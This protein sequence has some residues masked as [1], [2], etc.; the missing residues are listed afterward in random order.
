MTV[1]TASASNNL[2]FPSSCASSIFMIEQSW[3]SSTLRILRSIGSLVLCWRSIAL[4]SPQVVTMS[5]LWVMTSP[6]KLVTTTSRDMAKKTRAGDTFQLGLWTDRGLKKRGCSF[7]FTWPILIFKTD[8][9]QSVLEG[10]DTWSFLLSKEVW[11]PKI[12]ITEM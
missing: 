10:H 3:S 9:K 6:S 2:V 7:R 5:T 11:L 4:N 8:Q 1:A 12:R